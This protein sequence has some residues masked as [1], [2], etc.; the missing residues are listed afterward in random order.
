M[1]ETSRLISHGRIQLIGSL[2]TR[3]IIRAHMCNCSC[4]LARLAG[5]LLV[6]RAQIRGATIRCIVVGVMVLE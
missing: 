4:I 3:R 2:A 1:V 6:E 5:D